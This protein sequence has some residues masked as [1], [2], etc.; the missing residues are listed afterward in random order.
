M[1]GNQILSRLVMSVSH[2]STDRVAVDMNIQWT[3]KDG[4]LKSTICKI[5]ISLDLFN[6]DNFSIRGGYD[7]I[8][9]YCV[10]AAG[11]SE[12]R[13]NKY[14][15]NHRCNKDD[16]AYRWRIKTKN[17]KR[18]NVNGTKQN[19]TPCNDLIAVLMNGHFRVLT[20][21]YTETKS[22][23]PE[24]WPGGRSAIYLTKK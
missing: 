14:Q 5:F 13:N 7:G 17:V 8:F 1:P 10:L 18:K 3:H 21:K 20:S 9:I 6:G 19:D 24:S 12:K 4:H 22:G 11:D 23:Q 16:P 2:L 15:Q